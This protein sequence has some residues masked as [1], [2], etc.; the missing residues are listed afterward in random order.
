MGRKSVSAPKSNAS[1][2]TNEHFIN[3]Y[4]FDGHDTDTILF[5]LTRFERNLCFIKDSKERENLAKVHETEC[6]KFDELGRQRLQ[7]QIRKCKHAYKKTTENLD[8]MRLMNSNTGVARKICDIDIVETR[9]F[10]SGITAL[11]QVYGTDPT[12]GETGIPEG[13][14]TILGSPK[15]VGK[16]RLCAQI[17]S[18]VGNPKAPSNTRGDS[19]VLFIQNEEKVE[20][21]RSRYAKM[22]TNRHQ[23]LLSDS[24]DL[25]QQLALINK[26][27]PKLV[28]IDSIQDTLQARY[29]AGLANML[30]S[31]KSVAE[32]EGTAF[33]LISHVNGEGKL[34]G[35]TYAG[36]KVDIE[37]LIE[38]AMTPGEFILNCDE[39]NRYGATNKR[40]WFRHT[41]EGIESVSDQTNCD[42][43]VGVKALPAPQ[44]NVRTQTTVF[45]GR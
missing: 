11:D 1:S 10:S 30:C 6:P 8:Q 5:L 18:L 4:L 19:G 42:Y 31:Y 29:N 21:F 23:I 38:R 44:A 27:R 40:A 3:K 32:V 7:E 14:C 34:K 15:G 37:F 26:H 28:I 33:L 13:S 43:L 16:T 22:W 39:K 41:P 36:H 24:N 17:A 9:R 20:L 2:A 25:I 45:G 35:G 12:N